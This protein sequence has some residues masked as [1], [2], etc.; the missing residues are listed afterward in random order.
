MRW[1]VP[2]RPRLWSPWKW[3]MQIRVSGLT[4]RPAISIWRWVPSPGSNRIAS[5]SQRRRYPLWLQCRVGTW[6][7]VPRIVSSRMT[8]PGHEATP[9]DFHA[10]RRV[11][12]SDRAGSPGA[13][14]VSCIRRTAATRSRR[15]RSCQGQRLADSHLTSP[16]AIQ[17]RT[18]SLH[19]YRHVSHPGGVSTTLLASL[20]PREYPRGH[21]GAFHRK[22]GGAHELRIRRT[23]D[24]HVLVLV[25]ETV[26]HVPH[27]LE[28]GPLLVVAL[29][30]GPRRVR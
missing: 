24:L 11:V 25:F 23:G 19:V 9:G 14:V 6:L 1:M 2:G 29:H 17:L 5:S 16:V 4:A 15:V 28:P 27:R 30:H 26:Q 22:R 18:T 7:A 13:G 10:R 20:K 3:V 8:R 12:R 21:F